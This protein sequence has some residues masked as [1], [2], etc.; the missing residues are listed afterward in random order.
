MIWYGMSSPVL[1]YINRI[2][3]SLSWENIIYHYIQITYFVYIILIF[4]KDANK[5][6]EYL[7]H[8]RNIVSFGI[9]IRKIQIHYSC[10]KLVTKLC[11]IYYGAILFKGSYM[12]YRTNQFLCNVWINCIQKSSEIINEFVR[13]QSSISKHVVRA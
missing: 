2:F 7:K 12:N 5:I 11:S 9:Y 13:L 8:L 1:H 6:Y 4:Y 3:H 10:V